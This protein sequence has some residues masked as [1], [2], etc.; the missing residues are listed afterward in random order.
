MIRN[1]ILR[2]DLNRI[3][4]SPILWASV[5]VSMICMAL[6]LVN[7]KKE[8]LDQFVHQGTLNLFLFS[9]VVVGGGLLSVIAPVLPVLTFGTSIWDD[10]ESGYIRLIL[11]RMKFSKYI[12]QRILS[13]AISGGAVFLVSMMLNWGIMAL[14]DSSNSPVLDYGLVT[15][16]FGNVYAYSMLLYCALYV[17]L[18]TVFGALQALLATGVSLL[19]QNRYVGLIVPAVLYHSGRIFFALSGFRFSFL[20]WYSYSITDAKTSSG[21]VYYDYAFYMILFVILLFLGWKRVK[22]SGRL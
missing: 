9:A 15:K 6:N 4:K 20:P 12:R 21:E 16:A 14:L 8:Y 10:V 1:G 17:L 22:L 11:V 7:F 5:L 13:V 19:A 2:S 18:A 3:F